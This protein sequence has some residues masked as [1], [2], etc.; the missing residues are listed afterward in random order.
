MIDINMDLLQL[1]INLLIKKISGSGIKNEKNLKKEIA[2][3]LNTPIIRNFNK[4][5]VHLSFID[6]IWGPDSADMQLISKFN[7]GFRFFY[8]LLIFIANMLGLILWKIKKVL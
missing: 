6:N 5:E 2:E 8:V 3:E 7:N 1:F 4:K